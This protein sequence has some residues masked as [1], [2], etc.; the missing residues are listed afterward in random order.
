E[1]ATD[2]TPQRIHIRKLLQKVGLSAKQ[3]EELAYL[4]QFLQKLSNL[5][6][7]AGGEAPKPERPDTSF[8]DDI[9]LTAGNEQLVALYNRREELASNIET[10]ENLSE[11]IHQRW[12]S[13]AVLKRLM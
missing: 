10:W 1:S 7:E 6:D 9:R 4:P 5:A 13:W 8:L 12:P 11:R 2:T 3:G